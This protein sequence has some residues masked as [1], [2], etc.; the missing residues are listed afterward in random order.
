MM[1]QSKST[2]HSTPIPTQRSHRMAA[3]Y[4]SHPI[5]RET[6]NCT[7][8]RSSVTSRTRHAYLVGTNSIP[9]IGVEPLVA[10]R[11]RVSTSFTATSSIRR[12]I[13]NRAPP[14]SLTTPRSIRVGSSGHESWPRDEPMTGAEAGMIGARQ[15]LLQLKRCRIETVTAMMACRQWVCYR[16]QIRCAADSR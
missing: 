7:K 3:S 6:P 12:T 5:E 14:S 9:L 15:R 10:D 11:L 13:L 4:Y 16:E 8:L 2:R 1:D